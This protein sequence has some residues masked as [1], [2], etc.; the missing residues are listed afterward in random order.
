MM[1]LENIKVIVTGDVLSDSAIPSVAATQ[2]AALSKTDDFSVYMMP[3]S[4]VEN[5]KE[6]GIASIVDGGP[7]YL[8]VTF[9]KPDGTL[10][11]GVMRRNVQRYVDRLGAAMGSAE[12]NALAETVTLVNAA[13]NIGARIVVTRSTELLQAR[14]RGVGFLSTCGLLDPE[15]AVTICYA[16]LRGRNRYVT[17]KHPDYC[18]RSDETVFYSSL[19]SNLLGKTSKVLRHVMNPDFK[20][21]YELPASH[22]QAILT[23]FTDLLIAADELG[24]AYIS[25]GMNG[26]GN[27]QLIRQLSHL[28]NSIVAYSGALDAIAWVAKD[29]DST[30]VPGGKMSIAW[31]QL[32]KNEPKKLGSL[33]T[34]DAAIMQAAASAVDPVW[35]NFVND[36]REKVQHR[37]P[38]TGGIAQFVVSG[39]GNPE[40]S[41]S[42]VDLRESTS[43]EVS[44]PPG[45]YGVFRDGC[46]QPHVLQHEMVRSLQ[47]ILETVIGSLGWSDDSWIVDDEHSHG[48]LDEH[49]SFGRD[50]VQQWWWR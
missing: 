29:L 28:N 30:N 40:A 38:L 11:T 2:L 35:P 20:G 22:L 41:Y 39:N 47:G 36:L 12:R 24:R 10:Q 1:Q 42:V 32:V 33:V 45:M 43:A 5:W 16:L 14:K 17:Q 6:V 34:G 48:S 7:E 21:R 46:V 37:K 49:L 25:E 31:K 9:A 19:A 13:S 3:S 18:R 4:F 50:A 8:G 26:G 23:R 15:E 27:G 44:L